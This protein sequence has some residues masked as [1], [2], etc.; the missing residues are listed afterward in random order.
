M[1]MDKRTT[2]LQCETENVT[3]NKDLCEPSEPDKGVFLSVKEGNE[4]AKNHV[5]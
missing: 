2:S 3:G 5:D 4:A 1:A